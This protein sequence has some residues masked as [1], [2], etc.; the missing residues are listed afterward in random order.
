M[1]NKNKVKEYIMDLMIIFLGVWSL[2]CIHLFVINYSLQSGTKEEF[3]GI[4]AKVILSILFWVG[5]IYSLI[6]NSIKAHRDK[7]PLAKTFLK[8]CYPL[9]I[10]LAVI[11]VIFYKL[12]HYDSNYEIFYDINKLKDL[13]LN[14]EFFAIDLIIL[15]LLYFMPKEIRLYKAL[16]NT[17]LIKNFMILGAYL[18]MVSVI[19]L[20]DI[21]KKMNDTNLV[22]S[23]LECTDNYI[24]NND[25]FFLTSKECPYKDKTADE[26]AII[27]A[28][29]GN[30]IHYTKVLNSMK[31]ASNEDKVKLAKK[32]YQANLKFYNISWLE[33]NMPL[34]Y[35]NSLFKKNKDRNLAKKDQDLRMIGF[36][37]QGNRN[38][39][40]NYKNS[41]PKKE[42]SLLV[43]S[44]N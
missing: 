18:T 13:F 39:Y 29:K 10:Q 14:V 28:E 27:M 40:L 41:I 26:K 30:V 5:V 9:V 25:I 23:F 44:I 21:E 8:S 31:T 6:Y 32:Y 12:S 35:E 4:V 22:S 36:I 34:L 3:V 20:V 33:I 19:N 17:L 7:K 1:E 15:T 11:G 43:R 2:S 42:Q 38:S 24:V 16:F 37:E